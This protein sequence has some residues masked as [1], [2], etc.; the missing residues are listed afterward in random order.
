[1]LEAPREDA[2]PLTVAVLGAGL[3][4]AQ[5]AMD[6]ARAG[7]NVRFTV[8]NRT[9]SVA[10]L[11]RVRGTAEVPDGQ[12]GYAQDTDEAAA[13]AQLIVESLPEDLPLKQRELRRAQA[14][15]PKAILATNTSSLT[16]SSIAAALDDPTLLIGTHYVNPPWAH[17]MVEVISGEHTAQWVVGEVDR[18]L[19]SLGRIPIH[20]SGDVPGFVFNRLQFAL[21]REAID[22][23]DRGVVTKADLDQLMVEGLGRR[24]G[25]VGPFTAAGLGG[26]ELFFALAERLYPELSTAS[27]PSPEHLRHLTMPD[28]EIASARSVRDAALAREVVRAESVG[29]RISICPDPAAAPS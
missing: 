29:P 6:F 19:V 10:A 23:V 24:W 9:G 17:R 18:I 25:I 20:V 27:A 21:L 8:S 7:H 13:S 1:M 2:R 22:L 15:S 3:M 28:D 4:G 16:I 12:I 14:M 11:A 26:A 5:I